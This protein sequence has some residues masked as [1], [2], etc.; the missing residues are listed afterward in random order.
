MRGKLKNVSFSEQTKLPFSKLNY[1]SQEEG[2]YYVKFLETYLDIKC[3]L[4][5]FF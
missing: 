4:I 3:K 2:K 1:H 5:F